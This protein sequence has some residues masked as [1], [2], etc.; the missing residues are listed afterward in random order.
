MD[1]KKLLSK[2]KQIDLQTDL[3]RQR[4]IGSKEII[5]FTRQFA[6][7]LAAGIPMT[8]ALSGIAAGEVAHKRMREMILRIKFAVSTGKT[9]FEALRP[10]SKYFGSVYLALVRAGET[11]GFLDEVLCSLAVHLEKSEKIKKQII[12]AL[13]YPCCVIFSALCVTLLLLLYVIPTF[14]EMFNDAN[15]TLPALTQA[16]IN[17]SNLLLNNL[18]IFWVLVAAIFVAWHEARKNERVLNYLSRMI[19]KIPILGKT[20]LQLLI[21][22]FSRVFSAL[23]SAGIPIV[24]ALSISGS[25]IGNRE[26]EKEIFCIKCGVERGESFA[27]QVARSDYFPPLAYQFCHVGETTG[28]LDGMLVKIA[29]FYEEETSRFFANSKQLLEPAIILF[30]GVVVGTLVV[31]MYLP[32]LQLGQLV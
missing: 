13:I 16:V 17:I 27:Q 23:L 10:E 32:I 30:L 26:F 4:R 21:I 18:S 31:A 24:E 15:M 9:L 20:I 2:F 14:A 6:T 29:S 28:M 1:Y 25:T 11:G 22:R 7:M 8:D 5:F 12:G 3:S 19:L